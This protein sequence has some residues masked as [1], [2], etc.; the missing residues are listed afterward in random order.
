MLL[1]GPG[2]LGDDVHGAVVREGF[3]DR[4]DGGQ[5]GLVGDQEVVVGSVRRV[6]CGARSP[7]RDRIAGPGAG[8]PARG[9]AGVAVE[10]EE[11]VELGPLG[12]PAAERV[13]R[14]DGP[15]G[16][17]HLLVRL[18][19]EALVDGQLRA[20]RRR[21]QDVEERVGADGL[22]GG[23]VA[24]SEGD[25]PEVRVDVFDGVHAGE[26]RADGVHLPMLSIPTIN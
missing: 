3:E 14:A 18:P 12:A 19:R 1:A 15:V 13:V 8:G 5:T 17:G 2:H 22:E 11:H 23:E 7:E 10:H 9:G 6:P 26:E 21:Q 25:H 4:G 20:A 16:I 24:A